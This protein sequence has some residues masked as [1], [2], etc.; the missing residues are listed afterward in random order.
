MFLEKF[1]SEGFV[2]CAELVF[3]KNYKQLLLVTASY[4]LEMYRRHRN[5]FQGLFSFPEIPGYCNR[6]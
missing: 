5:A 2:Q 6:F 1:S 4:F 3:G